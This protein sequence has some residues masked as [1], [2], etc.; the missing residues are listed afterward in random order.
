MRVYFQ[1]R[2]LLHGSAKLLSQGNLMLAYPVN[3][4][5]RYM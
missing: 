4:H 5:D 2:M 1:T 3:A